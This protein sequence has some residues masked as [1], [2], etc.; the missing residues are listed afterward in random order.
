VIEVLGLLKILEPYSE[1]I[2]SAGIFVGGVGGLV[3]FIWKTRSESI[4]REKKIYDD[5]EA[6][7]FEINKLMMQHTD[8]D[9]SWFADHPGLRLSDA[10]QLR[11]DIMF[12]ILTRHFEQVYLN[13]R[14]APRRQYRAQWRGWDCYIE[15]YCK[16]SSYQ[17]WW[18]RSDWPLRS[19]SEGNISQYDKDLLPCLRC[20]PSYVTH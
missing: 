6:K 20:C 5:L 9:V 16:K 14:H 11:Q 2:K 4:A 1:L 7:Y 8:L 15:D 13:F 19:A 10:D 12:E 17:V 3:T 18:T